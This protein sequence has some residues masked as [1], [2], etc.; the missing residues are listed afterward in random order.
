MKRSSFYNQQKM[1][2][3]HQTMANKLSAKGSVELSCFFQMLVQEP[4]QLTNIID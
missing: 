1:G 3:K 2:L 4:T